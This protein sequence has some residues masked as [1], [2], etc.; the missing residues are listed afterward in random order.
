MLHTL[1]LWLPILASTVAV[2]FLSFLC[3][4]VLPHH[5]NDWGPLPSEDGL[6]D[7]LRAQD[8]GRGQYAFPRCK[9]PEEMRE[10]AFLEKYNRG[11]KGFL[12]VAPDGPLNMGR[13][14]GISSVYNLAV[15]T[16]V[17]YVATL[18]LPAGA[19]GMQVF[20]LV[21]TVA[22]LAHGSA[23]GWAPIWFGRTWGSTLREGLDALLY[24]LATGAIFLALWP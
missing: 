5:R 15:T 3:W 23:L 8:V 24:G 4:A 7:T 9:S 12:I 20:R 14:M 6:M 16:L 22:F 13:T 10:P 21:S 11:P 2:F 17:A 19:D 1:D 18:A